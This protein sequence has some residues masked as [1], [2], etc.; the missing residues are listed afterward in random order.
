MI[1][2]CKLCAHTWG[3]TMTPR[4]D[5]LC[6]SCASPT[7]SRNPGHYWK[8]RFWNYHSTKPHMIT[9]SPEWWDQQTDLVDLRYAIEV[10]SAWAVA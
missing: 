6:G 8:A 7:P 10:A 4:E 9:R 5:V 1:E 3:V 2:T